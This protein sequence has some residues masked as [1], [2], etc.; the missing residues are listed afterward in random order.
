MSTS[1]DY[2]MMGAIAGM[3]LVVTIVSL[4]VA[5]FAIICMWKIYEK[6]DEPGWAAIVPF[7]NT[8]VLFKITW[9]NGWF[10]L[11]CMIPF[12]NFV[13]LIITYWKLAKV[14]G[15]GVVEFLLLLFLPVV[16]FPIMA[17][18]GAEYEGIE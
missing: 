14:F 3:G 6:A 18:G 15:G 9:G 10:F 1:S 11:L 2:D 8:Y 4:V 16:A 12:A 5:V 13:V 7:Y 17:F